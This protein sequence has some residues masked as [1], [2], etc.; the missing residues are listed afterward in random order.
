[1]YTRKLSVIINCTQLRRCKRHLLRP[2]HDVGYQITRSISMTP[3]T[4]H[5]TK[6]AQEFH[7]ALRVKYHPNKTKNIRI[8]QKSAYH[9]HV[10]LPTSALF[11]TKKTTAARLHLRHSRSW[12]LPVY[13]W[14]QQKIAKEARVVHWHAKQTRSPVRNCHPVDNKPRLVAKE[15]CFYPGK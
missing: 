3:T 5:Q 6:A 8:T 12:N 4:R 10:L 15:Q 7:L 11:H 14:L 13:Q 2:N 9:S 1:M